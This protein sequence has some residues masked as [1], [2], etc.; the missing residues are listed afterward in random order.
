MPERKLSVAL[1]LP[2]LLEEYPRL[3]LK[4]AYKAAKEL[5]VNLTVLNIEPFDS[6]HGYR[7]QSNFLF[8]ILQSSF[9]DVIILAS[10]TLS[11]FISADR[12]QYLIE[13]LKNRQLISI[14]IPLKNAVTIMINN[15][16]AISKAVKHLTCVHN[17]KKLGFI[18]GPVNNFE[19]NERFNAFVSSLN[20]FGLPFNENLVFDGDF[21]V[22]SGEKV[23]E[24]ILENNLEMDGI[25]ASN[26]NM[27]IGLIRKLKEA[28]PEIL[29]NL[30]IIGFDDIEDSRYQIPSLSTIKQPIYKQGYIAVKTAY[31][32]YKEGF[33]TDKIVLPAFFVA[34]ESCGCSK[35]RKI[36]ILN[37]SEE[38]L[39][40]EIKGFIEVEE[41]GIK[42][43]EEV[44]SF[45]KDFIKKLAKEKISN[46]EE[47][48][49]IRDLKAI[50]KDLILEGEGILFFVN[51]LEL[52]ESAFPL[53]KYVIEKCKTAV[54]EIKNFFDNHLEKEI[55]IYERKV[56]EFLV[57]I[58]TS[59][60][61]DEWLNSIME[62]ATKLKWGSFYLFKFKNPVFH[63][64]GEDFIDRNETLLILA[65]K[66]KSSLKIQTRDGVKMSVDN[67]ISSFSDENRCFYFVLPVYFKEYIY[68]YFVLES[69]ILKPDYLYDLAETL[70]SSFFTLSVLERLKSESNIIKQKTEEIENELVFAELLQKNI[71]PKSSPR[72]YIDF[73]I[74]YKEKIGGDFL[75]F[76]NFRENDW[77][78]IF[79]ADVSGH[80]VPTAIITSA[81]KSSIL[82]LRAC[83]TSPSLFLLELNDTIYSM[84]KE[85]F[86]ATA[87]YGIYK[88][89]ENKLIFSNAGHN[90]PY[91]IYE[92]SVKQL[93]CRS[94]GLALGV[95]PKEELII[96]KKSYQDEEIILNDI[97]K[98]VFYTDGLTETSSKSNPQADFEN[99]ALKSLFLRNKEIPAKEFIE[100]VKNNLILFHGNENFDDD[101]AFICLDLNKFRK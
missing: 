14:G 70:S 80:G 58:N 13:K 48:K 99:Y 65:E 52:I 29:A 64:K 30:S 22:Y 90:N 60:N 4:G 68:G 51:I 19:A 94:T 1:Q 49:V 18:K 88:E 24:Q 83:L 32:I 84:T 73:Y 27:A 45:F 67:F 92:D 79:I 5:D 97:R 53:N 55:K 23:A 74:K 66:V 42:H 33:S 46:S 10:C 9:F 41:V 11:N 8:N 62:M 39:F 96:L 40:R 54:Y 15:D 17:K 63:V 69:E 98:I 85:G 31:E 16:N 71:L 26:D 50:L 36:N 76:I 35:D 37:F 89:N 56:K 87:F 72:E 91:L 57:K 3:L 75:D 20:K 100:K 86:F 95:A 81:I 101:V 82:Q 6:L 25:I 34:R 38:N 93:E 78:G 77:V 47:D 28:R 44:Y 7:Y 43:A 61:W 12:F 21:S 2:D 59:T